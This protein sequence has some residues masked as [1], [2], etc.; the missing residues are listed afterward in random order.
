MH[1]LY[2]RDKK[3]NIEKKYIVCYNEPIKKYEHL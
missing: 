3:G 1:E 2:S